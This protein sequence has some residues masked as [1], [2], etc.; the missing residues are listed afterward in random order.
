MDDMG[1]RGPEGRAA[2]PGGSGVGSTEDADFELARP[3]AS[4]SSGCGRLLAMAIAEEGHQEPKREKWLW[5]TLA[6]GAADIYIC[7][8]ARGGVW[9]CRESRNG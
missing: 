4:Q 5:R 2:G 3:H 6:L 1:E 8:L 9:R 7:I